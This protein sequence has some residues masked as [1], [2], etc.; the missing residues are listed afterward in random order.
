MA[1][2]YLHSEGIAHRDL[3]L[4]NVLIAE[5][6]YI[7]LIDFGLSKVIPSGIIVFIIF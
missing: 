5:N 6:G 2:G 7:R 4:E 1:I 3:K